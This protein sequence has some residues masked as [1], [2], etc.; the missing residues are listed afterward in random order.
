MVDTVDT[1]KP[2]FLIANITSIMYCTLTS[3]L[4]SLRM[5][6][7]LSYTPAD[8]TINNTTDTFKLHFQMIHAFTISNDN[9]THYKVSH[10]IPL[11]N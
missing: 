8:G 9:K 5:P 11:E 4:P 7:K 3:S 6:L 2:S 1:L 10:I